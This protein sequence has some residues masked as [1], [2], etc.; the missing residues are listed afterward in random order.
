MTYTRTMQTKSANAMAQRFAIDAVEGRRHNAAMFRDFIEWAIIAGI[1]ADV[2]KNVL[3]DMATGALDA[4]SNIT[5]ELH[6]ALD[7]ENLSHDMLLPLDVSELKV[8][9][10]KCK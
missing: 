9:A 2:D 5:G 7:A 1:E 4:I 8:L 6:A 3:H 10:E